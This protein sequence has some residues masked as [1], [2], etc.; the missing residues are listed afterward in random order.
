M[1]PELNRKA[2]GDT[3]R[4][5]LQRGSSERKAVFQMR[6]A[7]RSLS[8]VAWRVSTKAAGAAL[9]EADA[10]FLASLD[11]TEKGHVLSEALAWRET[12]APG[13][14]LREAKIE[15]F[16]DVVREMGLAYVHSL[17]SKYQEAY[18]E[19]RFPQ[20]PQQ[21]AE[22]PADIPCDSKLSFVQ[23]LSQG[24]VIVG[25]GML[26]LR[27]GHV[28][29]TVSICGSLTTNFESVSE[30]RQPSS[31][32]AV[33]VTFNGDGRFRVIDPANLTHLDGHVAPDDDAGPDIFK[34]YIE[35]IGDRNHVLVLHTKDSEM[36]FVVP[37]GC[38]EDEWLRQESLS[39][40]RES[41]K[42]SEQAQRKAIRA[43][44]AGLAADLCK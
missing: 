22:L 32:K 5:L 15:N 23:L 7:L 44:Y 14:Y 37:P 28:F 38:R 24:N 3:C 1:K 27:T 33:A 31:G 11:G 16:E 9:C 30:A 13:Q 8:K 2:G 42:L 29:N 34:P 17:I 43:K 36:T 19:S 18:T 26:C 25:G 4:N 39:A 41:I 40:M 35:R 20:G 6:D 21:I 10:A 12:L